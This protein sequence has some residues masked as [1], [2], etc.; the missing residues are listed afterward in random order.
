MYIAFTVVFFAFI[1]TVAS[2][3]GTQKKW[4]AS[5]SQSRIA[6]GSVS[7]YVTS[8]VPYSASDEDKMVKDLS[9]LSTYGNPFMVHLGNIQESKV[10]LCQSSRYSD[11]AEMLKNSPMPMFVLPGEEDWSNCPDPNAAWN[12][13]SESFSYFDSN[14]NKPFPLQRIV[15]RT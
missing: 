14:F 11:V 9:T 12:S 6:P 15:S 2:V 7:F 10:T 5:G 8:N 1:V 3:L 13:W 4:G